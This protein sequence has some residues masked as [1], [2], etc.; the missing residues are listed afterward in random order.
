MK[1]VCILVLSA[2]IM[3]YM[4]YTICTRPNKACPILNGDGGGVDGG[5]IGRRWEEMREGKLVGM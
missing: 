3:E 2:K 5:R 4:L 1:M